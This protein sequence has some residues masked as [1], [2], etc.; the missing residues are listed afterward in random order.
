MIK[1]NDN[2]RTGEHGKRLKRH[3]LDRVETPFLDQLRKLGWSGGFN[4]VIT[5]DL[6]QSPQESYRNSFNEVV[7]MPKLREALMRLNPWLTPQQLDEVATRM[8]SFSSG[9]LIENNRAVLEMILEG[10]AVDRNEQTGEIS[11]KVRFINF[12]D[13]TK[14]ALTA[15][16]QFKVAIPGTEHHIIPDIVLFVNGL[17]VGVVECKSPKIIDAI[18]EAIDQLMR[19]S[20][21]RDA[22]LEGNKEL[23]AYNQ[24]LIVTSRNQAKFGTITTKSEKHFY[25][26]TDPYP[27][28]V[29]DLEHG[30]GSPNDQQRLVAGMLAPQ[31][32]FDLIRIFTVFSTNSKGK[33]IKIVGR[34]QQFRAVKKMAARLLAGRTPLERGGIL[35]HTQG[36]GKSLTMM[37]LV[38]QMRLDPE[39]CQWKVVFVTDRSQLESQLSQTGTGVGYN[40]KVAARIDPVMLPDGSVSTKKSHLSLKGLLANNSSDLVMA[41]IHKFQENDELGTGA[42][43]PVLNRSEKI[44]IMTDE[45]HRSQ[46][47]LLG[48]NLDRALPNSTRIGFTGTPTKKTELLYRDYIDRYTMRESIADG[49][50]LEIIYQGFTHNAEIEDSTGADKL[51]EDVFSDYRLDERL[52][53]LG[54]G[55]R[56]AY[57]NSEVTIRAKAKNMMAHYVSQIFSGGFKAQIIANSREAAVTYKR[58]VEDALAEEIVQL[59]QNNPNCIDIEKL[60]KVK[61]AVVISGRHNDLPII[62]Q[63]TDKTYHDRSIASFK[64]AYGDVDEEDN[65]IDGNVGVVIVN[66]MLTTGF[67]APIEQV[68][69]LDRVII[70]HNLLQAITRPNRVEDEKDYGFVVDY[71]GIGHHLREAILKTDQRQEQVD[72]GEI[73]DIIESFG[74]TDDLLRALVESHKKIMDFIKPQG[75]TDLEDEDAFYEMFYDEEIRSKYIDLYRAFSSAFNALQPAKEALDFYHDWLA[76]TEINALAMKHISDGRLSMKGLTPK[77]VAIANKHLVDKGVDEKVKPISIMAEDFLKETMK[78]KTEKSRAAQVEHAIRNYIEINID[79]DP[80]LFASFAE[81]IEQILKDFA[82]NWKKIYEELEKLREKIRNREHEETYG[83]D[84]KSQMPFF[85]LFKK[86]LWGDAPLSEDEIGKNVELTTAIFG[87]LH[88]ELQ[89]VGF[90]ESASAPIGLREK[91]LNTL[92]LP[93]FCTLPNIVAKRNEIISRIMEIARAKHSAILNYN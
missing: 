29:Q 37:F 44:L 56:D 6:Q 68:L 9:K 28:T 80:E 57:L 4:E 51:F 46:Y 8:T 69:Y 33:T 83:L 38:R 85:R 20:E 91:I 30:Q 82:G 89:L 42:I 90:W 67:D 34:Y 70:A 53:I 62:K 75:V 55:S 73:K 11:P 26:W 72:S 19:Y 25:R 45:A 48:S 18:P 78:R 3:E 21:Q 10:T 39:L 81:A 35:W 12:E 88:T 87:V 77:L 59:E 54:H 71:V 5:L 27:L 74:T 86:E 41:M 7:L 60:K 24:F 17:P 63:Y 66:N 14:N 2:K 23:F 61:A 76:L 92:L 50:T 1:S 13:I 36:S 79:E 32:L 31:N 58:A 84:R 64:L 93:E 49:V 40:L 47:S 43:F 16:S 65:A 52:Q 22:E 15:I